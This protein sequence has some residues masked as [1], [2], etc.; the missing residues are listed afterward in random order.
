MK[1]RV[2]VLL[3]VVLALLTGVIASPAHAL[4]LTEIQ[5]LLASDGEAF[6]DFGVSVAVDENTAVI[7]ARL[8]NDNGSDSGSA[9][10][11]T[12]DVNGDWTE[13][14]KLTASDGAAFDRF[15]MR[16]AVDGDTVVIG[17]E[18]DDDDGASSGSAYVFTRS[19]GV[20]T[21]Q[22]KLT[23]SDAAAGD[24]FGSAVAVDGGTAIIG[25]EREDQ[26]GSNSGSAYVFTRNAG[27]WTEQQK[28]TAGNGTDFDDF[29]N[30]I[31]MD[32]NTAVIGARF[33][34]IGNLFVEQDFGTAYVF[35]SNAGV[36]TEQQML[37]ASDGV[38]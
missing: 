5:K 7:G 32:G 16:V 28:L 31:A 13:Q 19:G 25:A 23:A 17:A 4:T 2:E 14:Q 15:G 6:D 37:S 27:V 8:D 36:W 38:K 18:S 34:D 9:Y 33:G 35:T 20:W 1:P 29:G 24:L 10:V 12:R 26:N 30:S 22:P 3:V 21:E 11:F